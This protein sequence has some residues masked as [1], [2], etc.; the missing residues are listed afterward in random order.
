MFDGQSLSSDEGFAFIRSWLAQRCGIFYAD[1]KEE[2][3][4]YR[5][6]RVIE[7][8]GLDGVGDLARRVER[9][10]QHEILLAVMHAASTNHTFFFRE[11][12]VL[13]FFRDTILPSL[14]QLSD[15]R[16]W[17]A[18]AATGD[19]AYTLGI[20]AAESWGL[21]RVLGRLAILGT[22]ISAPVIAQAESG[23]FAASH[24]EQMPKFLKDKYF[25]PHGI[26]QY[27]ITSEIR[28]ICTFRRLNL[29]SIPY[30]FQK[31]FSVIFCR[32]I[33]YYFER[34]DQFKLLETLYD[35]TEPSGWLLTSVTE[36]LRDLGTRWLSVD[37]GIYRRR[38]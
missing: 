15:L 13:D 20:I 14:S 30:P 18:A 1:R 36:S 24:L 11:P 7:R 16:I 12:A 23:V 37:S 29:K 35:V 31:P 4:A 38:P 2:L 9:G 28:S 10:D 21:D 22:D 3:L 27:Q 17:S 32:N 34:D 25:R 5:L 19:E 6:V 8:F 33:L 26:G